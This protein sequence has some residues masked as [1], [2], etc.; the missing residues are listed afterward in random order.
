[1]SLSA[2]TPHP[3][4]VTDPFAITGTDGRTH[5]IPVGPCLIDELE[6]DLV[7]LVWGKAGEKSAVVPTIEAERA[8]RAG[9]LVLLD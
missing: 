9:K 4:R 6:G 2:R 5:K 7:D 8:E 3:A 1:M